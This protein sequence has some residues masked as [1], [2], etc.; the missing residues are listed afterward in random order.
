MKK[1]RIWPK[2]PT[3]TI[4]LVLLCIGLIGPLL[5]I[6]A[7]SFFRTNE[8]WQHLLLLLLPR[9]LRQTLILAA[10]VAAGTGIFGVW[11]AW[12]ISHY[13][14]KGKKILEA[15]SYL[16]LAVPAY[17]LAFVYANFFS[18]SG[19]FRIS[20][21]KLT[22][23]SSSQLPNIDIMNMTGLIIVMT[24]ALFPYVFTA[25]RASF[26]IQSSALLEAASSLGV[27]RRKAFWTIA[28]PL[29]RPAIAAGISL[30]LME[31]LSEYGAVQYF[32]VE[33]FTTGIFRAW[34]TLRD[35][36]LALKL[37]GLLLI[38][39][40]GFII[41]E[42]KS[43]G[44]QKKYTSSQ[45]TKQEAF[46]KPLKGI[47]YIISMIVV[48]LPILLGFV[49]PVLLLIVWG[50]PE[51]TKIPADLGIHLLQTLGIG[52]LSTAATVIAAVI[53]VHGKT[54]LGQSP[55]NRLIRFSTMGYGIPGAVLA[56]AVLITSNTLLHGLKNSGIISLAN[57]RNLL[58][59]IG[60]FSLM[61]AF[62]IRYLAVAYKPISAHYQR[63]GGSLVEASLGLGVSPMRTLISVNIPLLKTPLLIGSLLVFI[64]LIKELPI[65][66]I[67]RPFNFGTLATTA[68]Y[69][70]SNEMLSQAA[71]YSLLIVVLGLIPT[72]GIVYLK[73]RKKR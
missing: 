60:F 39:T 28:L 14:F 65:T 41:I 47:H 71:P 37:A 23:L 73:E 55:I 5:Y 16:P 69:Y 7:A 26:G 27:S 72:L 59:S 48:I 67:L 64:D 32:G 36:G 10:G 24:L 70:A 63:V 50:I 66:M 42:K 11:S 34:F 29:A 40:F 58:Q 1:R 61:T 31:T 38:F 33:N 35:T 43:R 17:I 8:N 18:V 46:E 44:K 20:L 51:I 6:V 15:C 4:L 19:P 30:V 68:Y 25:A 12:I 49:L 52:I 62:V 21:Q 57:A 2:R 53:L 3:W 9:Y 56:L 22:G 54:I 45:S 13:S